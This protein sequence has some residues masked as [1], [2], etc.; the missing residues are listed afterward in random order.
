M[1]K[2]IG[3]VSLLII[4]Y[5]ISLILFGL[6]FG[7]MRL[8][9]TMVYLAD[10]GFG[11]PIVV[12]VPFVVACVYH[13][14]FASIIAICMIFLKKIPS[15]YRNTIY[16]FPILDIFLALPMMMPTVMLANL[17]NIHMLNP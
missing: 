5:L 6:I 17:L 16:T 2:N 14:I 1:L 7:A 10:E 11:G 15:I 8:N 12:F 9:E 4:L 3:K 13:F